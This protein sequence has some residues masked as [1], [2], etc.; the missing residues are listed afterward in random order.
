MNIKR[1][2]VGSLAAFAATLLTCAVVTLMWNLALHRRGTIDW[3]T[4]FRF[5][6]VLGILLPWITLGIRRNK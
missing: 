1:I 4:S 5:A 6:I 2:V 3:S